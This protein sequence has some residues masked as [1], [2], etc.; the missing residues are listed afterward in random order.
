MTIEQSTQRTVTQFILKC[1]VKH[2]GA[3]YKEKGKE[4]AAT[5]I[6]APTTTHWE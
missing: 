6:Q 5:M 4:T 2:E 1:A 3:H